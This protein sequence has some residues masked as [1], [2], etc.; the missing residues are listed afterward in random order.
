MRSDIVDPARGPLVPI[1]PPVVQIQRYDL[2]PLRGAAQKARIDSTILYLATQ[3]LQIHF[4]PIYVEQ[5][6]D[7]VFCEN[8]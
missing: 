5:T 8:W 2:K 3:G 6:S 7:P 4:P 1:S